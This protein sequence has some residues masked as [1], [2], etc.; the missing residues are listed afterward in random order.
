MKHGFTQDEIGAAIGV[1][2]GSI[3]KLI[4]GRQADLMGQKYIKLL[5]MHGKYVRK[6][7]KAVSEI[8]QQIS[9]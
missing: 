7:R 5:A 1:T 8:A 4:T 6:T 3:S 9:V 2:Q